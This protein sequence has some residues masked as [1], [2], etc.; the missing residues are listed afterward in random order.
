MATIP[1]GTE[2]RD[3]A[4]NLVCRFAKDLHVGEFIGVGL[5]TDWQ[6]EEPIPGEQMHPAIVDFFKAHPA[7]SSR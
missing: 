4:G 1:K 2:V 7:L 3:D 5:F 6:G